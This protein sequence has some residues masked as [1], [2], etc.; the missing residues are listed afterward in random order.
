MT[1]HIFISILNVI[2]K[3]SEAIKY[4]VQHSSPFSSSAVHMGAEM[5]FE[6]YSKYGVMEQRQGSPHLTSHIK[7]QLLID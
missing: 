1:C 5:T 4:T 7:I 6:H 3:Q 2:K